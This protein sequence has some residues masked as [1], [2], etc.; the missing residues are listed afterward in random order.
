[1][2]YLDTSALVK[3]V[4]SEA[5][6]AA[7]RRFI[8][9][10]DPQSLVT[11]ALTRAELLRAALRRNAA[12]VQKARDVLEGV[13]TITITEALLDSAGLIEPSGLRTLDA[14]HLVTAI[15]LGTDL[16]QFVAYDARLLAAAREAGLPTLAPS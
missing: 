2:V 7:L 16:R 10:V 14:I 9:R 6:S 12:S 1:M 5:D 11:S 8:S 13:A 4:V 3:L 15:E